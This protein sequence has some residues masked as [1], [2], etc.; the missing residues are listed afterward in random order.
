MKY[1]L[2]FIQFFLLV[3]LSTYAQPSVVNEISAKKTNSPFS[4]GFGSVLSSVNVARNYKENPY[5]LGWTVRSTYDLNDNFH[6]T[7]EYASI[8][9]FDLSPTWLGIKSNSIALS[10]NTV[11][12]I[13]DQEIMIYTISGLC[14][15]TWKGFYTGTQDFSTARFYYKELSFVRNKNLCLD[16]GI[17][18]Q[19]PFPGFDLFGD[20]RYRFANIDSRFGIIDANFNLGVKFPVFKL[21]KDSL[22]KK[23][24]KRK[25]TKSSDKYHWF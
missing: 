14:I 15:Q 20:F 1:S 19:R 23:K 10:V 3:S 6:L 24:R 11:G 9:K 2:F 16:L 25:T 7:A 8:P 17:G 22:M 13:K 12:Y 5:H 18:F 21:K 4:L